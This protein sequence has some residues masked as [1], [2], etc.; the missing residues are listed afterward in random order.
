MVC[1]YKSVGGADGVM[2][3]HWLERNDI[4]ALLR[5]GL[6]GL[7]GEIPVADARASVWVRKEDEER[8]LEAVA[9]FHGPVQVHPKWVC[10]C[11]EESEP[12]F[13]SC[14]NC[15]ADRPDLR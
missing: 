2:I 5:G 9:A 6:S 10:T 13:G 8:A 15:G 1:V 7:A 14:W 12:N 11:G 4:P 3:Q